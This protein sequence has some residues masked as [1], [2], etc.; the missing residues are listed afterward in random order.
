[1]DLNAQLKSG[2]TEG[3]DNLNIPDKKDK[4]G[5]AKTPKGKTPT[6]LPRS[7]DAPKPKKKINFGAVLN[8]VIL[9]VIIIIL[10]SLTG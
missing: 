4:I 5:S 10:S 1:M 3:G 8:W 2:E 7:K 6:K 9:F